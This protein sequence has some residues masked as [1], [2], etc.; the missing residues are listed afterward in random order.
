MKSPFE[1]SA[2]E[3]TALFT[4]ATVLAMLAGFYQNRMLIRM[5]LAPLI[6]EINV[7]RS[8][9]GLIHFGVPKDS[10]Y[11]IAE[12]RITPRNMVLRRFE[13]TGAL[14]EYGEQDSAGCGPWANTITFKQPTHSVTLMTRE[15][16]AGRY[17][18]KITADML[19]GKSINLDVAEW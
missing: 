4:G 1:W 12:I 13:P 19:P 6:P 16:R 2:E 15:P 14:N 8:S 11:R 7:A 17:R 9:G 10:R 3:W 18:V 5:G